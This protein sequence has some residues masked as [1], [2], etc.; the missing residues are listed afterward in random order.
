MSSRKL[1]GP[2]DGYQ[3]SDQRAVQFLQR[4]LSESQRMADE[5]TR[6]Q[7]QQQRLYAELG[8]DIFQQWTREHLEETVKNAMRKAEEDAMHVER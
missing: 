4:A 3:I 1:N 7:R 2:P 6:S 8:E 5:T